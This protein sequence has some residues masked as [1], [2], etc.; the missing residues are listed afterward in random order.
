MGQDVSLDMTPTD[1]QKAREAAAAKATKVA[2][3]KWLGPGFLHRIVGGTVKMFQPGDYVHEPAH[4]A[5][6]T[7]EDFKLW[8]AEGKLKE[9]KFTEKI[10]AGVKVAVGLDDDHLVG[11]RVSDK[12]LAE[13]EARYTQ[14]MK[15]NAMKQKLAEKAVVAEAAPAFAALVAARKVAKE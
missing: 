11:E 12:E 6:V 14:T 1:E 7:L 5:T 2:A 10:I 4:L 13:A 15:T 8:L 3:F 9:L